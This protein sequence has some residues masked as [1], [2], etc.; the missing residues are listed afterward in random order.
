M[1]ISIATPYTQKVSGEHSA[2]GYIHMLFCPK[3]VCVSV[4]VLIFSS[5]IYQP[6]VFGAMIHRDEA[7]E[8][9]F[10]QYTKIIGATPHV[11]VTNSE[12]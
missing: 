12:T 2:L 11:T 4:I 6:L 8:A 9:I 3:C 1:G 5:V 7:F 10:S